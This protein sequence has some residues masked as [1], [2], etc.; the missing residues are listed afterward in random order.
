MSKSWQYETVL[1]GGVLRIGHVEKTGRPILFKGT[2]AS[3]YILFSGF[4]WKTL[5]SPT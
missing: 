2:Y 5:G 3:V 1:V 4:E